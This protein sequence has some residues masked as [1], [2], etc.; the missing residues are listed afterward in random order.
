[1]SLTRVRAFLVLGVLMVSAL[2]VVIV[3]VT[4]DTQNG[5]VADACKGAVL[6]NVTLPRGTSDV[7]VKVLN[8]TGRPGLAAALTQD[9]KNRGFTTQKPAESKKRFTGVA[10]VQYG[11]KGLSS[12]WLIQAFFLNESKSEYDPKRTDAT[13]NLVVGTLYRQL[14][15][16]T[17]VNQSLSILGSP[18]VPPGACA[19]PHDQLQAAK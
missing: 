12:A 2:V 8:G 9:M 1:M 13:V 3:A 15:T 10:L 6:V 7:T 4:K 18:V 5:P 17:E 16:P 19:A 11:P 14:A